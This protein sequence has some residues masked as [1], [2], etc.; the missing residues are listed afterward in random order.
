MSGASAVASPRDAPL[1]AALARLAERAGDDLDLSADVGPAPVGGGW[2]D[3]DALLV[4]PTLADALARVG[5]DAG[6]DEPR[7]Q[8][9]WLLEGYAWA[10][11]APVIGCALLRAPVPDVADGN[12]AVRL[13]ED[14]GIAAMRFRSGHGAMSCG[15]MDHVYAWLRRRL[16]EHLEPVVARM[17][18]VTRR[19]ERALW[20]C[21]EDSCAGAFLWLGDALS[22][23]ERAR[24][25]ADR[26]LGVEPPLRLPAQFVEV[27]YSRGVDVIRARRGCCLSYRRP[28]HESCCFTC[29]RTTTGERVRRL[30][31]R[32][33]A[34]NE[35]D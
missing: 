23:S 24:A 16:V 8:G 31:E 19:G 10:I 35:E 1:A 2:L 28:G 25:D 29:P 11:A 5:E 4:P 6:T 14:G 3:R 22:E 26:L 34:P 13:G 9:T 12:V 32:A 17:R 33:P 27:P 20:A 15:D 7:I 30:E 18:A 21:V